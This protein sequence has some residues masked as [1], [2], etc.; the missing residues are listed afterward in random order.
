MTNDID[1]ETQERPVAAAPAH[2]IT[3]SRLSDLQ[4]EARL[5]LAVLDDAAE[6][7]R[8]THGVLSHRARMLG[9]EA[10]RWVMSEDASH[11]FAFR[12]ICQYF[13]LDPAWVRSGLARWRPV[14]PRSSGH[15]LAAPSRRRGAA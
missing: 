2:G 3:R 5:A 9:V 8:A 14:P 10:W 4:P 15:D 1:D 6:T 7:L 11:P 12:A 13:E